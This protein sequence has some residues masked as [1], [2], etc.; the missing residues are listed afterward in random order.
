MTPHVTSP[1]EILCE[2]HNGSSPSQIIFQVIASR[3]RMAL[4]RPG[5]FRP[6]PAVSHLEQLM[7]A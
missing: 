2:P 5:R 7:L 4:E 1:D 3:D 6:F